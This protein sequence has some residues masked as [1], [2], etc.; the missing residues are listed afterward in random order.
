MSDPVASTI[1][2]P[3]LRAL[4]YGHTGSRKTSL[5]KT[6]PKPMLV[7]FWDAHGKDYPFW[8]DSAHRLLPS[9]AIGALQEYHI[10]TDPKTGAYVTI[11]YRDIQHPDGL[12]RLEYYHDEDPELPKAFA[13]WRVRRAQFPSE[14]HQWRT[15][16]LDSL[17]A[18]ELASRLQHKYVLNPQTDKEFKSR[19]PRK[20]FGGSTDDIEEALKVA[21]MGYTLNVVVTAHVDLERDES[22]IAGMSVRNPAA[23][24]RLRGG[25]AQQFMELWYSY[26]YTDP[27][28]KQTYG[29]IQTRPN[30]TFNASSQIDVPDGCYGHYDYIWAH[31]DAQQQ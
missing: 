18:C 27:A 4:I 11:K 25:L 17:T 22:S 9:S 7:W 14:M 28:S 15:L 12:I 23:P 29:M 16:G 26:I 19:D 1:I 8:R 10:P 2:R 13:N 30:G 21:F 24:G 3:D 5:L 31:Y 6:F 20:W